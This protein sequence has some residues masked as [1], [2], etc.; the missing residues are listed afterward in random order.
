[1]QAN[2][3]FNDDNPKHIADTLLYVGGDFTNP[4]PGF[5]YWI[6]DNAYANNMTP[7]W[8]CG[9]LRILTIIIPSR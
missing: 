8:G 6:T 2:L 9:G 4:L 3:Y 5:G 1:M 7:Y